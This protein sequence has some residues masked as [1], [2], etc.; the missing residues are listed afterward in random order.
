MQ[1]G[2]KF[3]FAGWQSACFWVGSPWRR[4]LLS[5]SVV[6]YVSSMY[7]DWFDITLLFYYKCWVCFRW[8]YFE[9]NCCCSHSTIHQCWWWILYFDIQFFLDLLRYEIFKVFEFR[10]RISSS[11][12]V[13]ASSSLWCY[14]VVWLNV[15]ELAR[16]GLGWASLKWLLSLLCFISHELFVCVF[17]RVGAR[18]VH[19]YSK[20][21]FDYSSLYLVRLEYL[22]LFTH[23]IQKDNLYRI[24]RL[25]HVVSSYWPSIYTSIIFSINMFNP[26]LPITINNVFICWSMNFLV[27]ILES[28]LLIAWKTSSLLLIWS[29]TFRCPISYATLSLLEPPTILLYKIHLLLLFFWKSSTSNSTI[30]P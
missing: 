2:R 21:K 13:K 4:V 24:L 22:Q 6:V 27:F 1:W 28:F 19:H 25:D 8:V 30:I 3:W 29:L 5:F 26:H 9:L 18:Y 12:V 16:Y 11:A 14:V 20:D 10:H 17:V 15:F 23:I 7:G